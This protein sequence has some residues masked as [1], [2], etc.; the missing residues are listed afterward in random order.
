M[1]K[2]ICSKFFLSLKYA[3][4]VNNNIL[5]TMFNISEGC[6]NCKMILWFLEFAAPTQNHS[7]L[8]PNYKTGT[9]H[10]S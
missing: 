3:R 1:K 6:L 5:D 2:L 7:F 9:F 8:A 4:S 10:L